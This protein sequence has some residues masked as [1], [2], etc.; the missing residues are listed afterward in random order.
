[1]DVAHEWDEN[2]SIDHAVYQKAARDGLLLPMYGGAKI[3][4]E[5]EQYGKI[6]GGLKAEEYDGMCDFIMNDELSRPGMFVLF[7]ESARESERAILIF[8]NF[9]RRVCR[10]PGR[11][12]RWRNVRSA[13]TL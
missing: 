1:M 4:K 2:K 13:F 5:W 6:I 8:Y 11:I 12:V 7:R 9:C 3:P 10:M